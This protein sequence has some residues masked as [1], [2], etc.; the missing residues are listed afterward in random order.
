MLSSSFAKYNILLRR[1]FNRHKFR[2]K[3][4]AQCRYERKY[5]LIVLGVVSMYAL[6]DYASQ[7]FLVLPSFISLERNEAQNIMRRCVVALKREISNLD[8]A[9]EDLQR[10]MIHI[11]LS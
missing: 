7:Y 10:Q 1:N 11:N 3:G 5:Y 8:K 9:A 6:L 4:N 2:Q